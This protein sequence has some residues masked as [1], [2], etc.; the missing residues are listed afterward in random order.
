MENYYEILGVS[1]TATQE[2]IKKAYRKKAVEHHPDKGGSEETFK[3]I[4]SAYDTLGDE[5]KRKSY[6]QKRKNPFSNDNTGFNPFEEFINRTFNQRKRSVPDKVIE[7][8]IGV[9]ESF[10]EVEK[11]INFFRNYG[12]TTCNGSGGERTVCNICKG[13]GFISIRQG[14]G[15][16]VQI[17]KQICHGCQ[18]KGSELKN[19]CFSCGGSGTITNADTISL[20]IPHGIETGQHFKIKSRGDF[21]NGSYNDLTIR[22]VLVPENN[23]EKSGNDL[24]YNLFYS[25]EDLNKTSIEIPHPNGV[26][27]INLPKE[28]DTSKPLRVKSKGFNLNGQGDLFIRQYVKFKRNS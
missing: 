25:L 26:I 15:L 2:E 7:V 21:I 10:N 4:A 28:I 23:F 12:C 14:T 1:E 27:N 9:L 3:K 11:T 22:V 17:T 19:A 5:T 6:D 18:G 20:R 16:F 13:Q 24:V 8:N